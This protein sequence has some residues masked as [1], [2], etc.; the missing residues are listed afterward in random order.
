MQTAA[1]NIAGYRE[2]RAP[3]SWPNGL[4]AVAAA[5][6]FAQAVFLAAAYVKGY[7]FIGPDGTPNATDFVGFWPAGRLVLDGQITSIYNEAAHKAAG[8]A[9]VGH[10]FH[11]T[12]PL[13]YP[14]HYM[15]L[16]AA[17]P[18][19][20]YTLSY[21][22]WVALTPVP[23]VFVISR[24]VGCRSGIVFALAFPALV[25]NAIVGQN[26]CITAALFGGALAAMQRRPVLAG[27]LIGLL[28]YKP[29]FGILI[30]LALAASRQGRSF[31]SAAVTAAVL[32]LVSSGI[33]GTAA[34]SGFFEAIMS[35]NRN[36]LSAGMH[37]LSKLQSLFGLVRVLGGDVR[38][39]W[40][41]QAGTMLSMAVFVCAAWAG[42]QPFAMK[43]A[44]L[45]AG[46]AISS[47]Y[48]YMYDLVLLAVPLAYLLADGRDRG[49]LPGEMLGLAAICL[50]LAVYPL[51][52]LPV[53]AVAMLLIVGMI[54]R[55]FL[56]APLA[57]PWD[58]Q[59]API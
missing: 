27:I 34:W 50:L 33:L 55:R 45:S 21:V 29:H 8:V 32:I 41:V 17:L 3:T 28:T 16:M 7:W 6:L 51:V 31:I 23:Y 48:A 58:A 26:G 43:A 59:A 5:L 57:A 9:A 52:Q 37:D 38:L 30:P 40:L 35:A 10:D 46:A 44:V 56:T 20:P 2:R 39:A 12:Y 19:L 53:G 18:L 24:I 36:T 22:A 15:L 11:G 1:G 13:F 49:F 25:A 14:P 47:P 42:P 4:E 54:A